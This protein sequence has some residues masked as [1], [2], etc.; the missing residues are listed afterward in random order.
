MSLARIAVLILLL[1]PTVLVMAQPAD[2]VGV[3]SDTTLLRVAE[4]FPPDTAF[5]PVDTVA[6]AAPGETVVDTLPAA[7]RMDRRDLPWRERHSPRKATILSAVVP[8]AGQIYNRKYWKAPI[9]W[10]GLGI[11]YTFIQDNTREYQRYRTAYLALVDGDPDTV[12]EFEGQYA[13]S[14]VRVVMETYQRWRDVSYIA[15]AGVYILNIID[16]SV[17]AHFVRF[18]VSPDLT[19]GIGPSLPVAAMG[20]MGLSFSLAVR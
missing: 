5:I 8:G 9:V 6:A 4:P 16:A 14:E 7:A 20:G 18:D 3:R 10:A 2:T 11:T 12:D 1:I 13:P 19:L 17:D 15:I